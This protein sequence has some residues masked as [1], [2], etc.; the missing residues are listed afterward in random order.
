MRWTIVCEAKRGEIERKGVISGRD[1]YGLT[2]AA[3]VRGAT[4]AAGRA[5]R[6]AAAWPPPRRSSPRTFL[7]GL[8]RFDVRWEVSE[9][10]S[11]SPVEA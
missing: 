8:E 9:P 1:V 6:A 10:A 11:R 4:I 7:E 3:I 2:A 5:S